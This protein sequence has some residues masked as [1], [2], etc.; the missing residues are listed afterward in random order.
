MNRYYI[1]FPERR[2]IKVHGLE[3][4]F[5]VIE[6]IRRSSS[7]IDED[8]EIYITN[9]FDSTITLEELKMYIDRAFFERG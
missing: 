6:E 8:D 4:L 7:I 2:E 1:E 3:E 9:S 5:H